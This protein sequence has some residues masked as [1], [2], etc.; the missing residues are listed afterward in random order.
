MALP[1]SVA[2]QRL[3]GPG[4]L[5]VSLARHGDEV[6]AAQRLR[7]QI[8]SEEFGARLPEV[9]PGLDVDEFDPFCE[10]LLV[11]EQAGGR[12]V[13]TYRLLPPERRQQAGGYYAEKEFDLG[14]FLNPRMRY[15]EIGRSCV[16]RDYRNGAVIA[17]LWSGIADFMQAWRVDHL[18][19]CA[20]VP[21]E[22]GA[23]VGALYRQLAEKSLL[24]AAQRVFPK[25]PLP[26]FNAFARAEPAAMPPL[27]KGYLRAG[28]MI[29]GEPCWDPDFR[30]VDFFV[31]LN[32]VQVA[33]RYRRHFV[34]S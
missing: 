27:L 29:G 33:P 32:A 14:R 26:L 23:Q 6:K 24:P 12:I 17:L 30:G 28:A 3:S 25:R 20:S 18:M 8:F 5:Q 7:Y 22:A 19:G 31:C 4:Q 34:G 1:V 9:E 10:H 13:G 21:N 2:R 11:R 16:H 15:L